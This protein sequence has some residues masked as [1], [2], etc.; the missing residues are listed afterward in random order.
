M[1]TN[2][3]GTATA[4]IAV[5]LSTALS[6]ANDNVPSGTIVGTVTSDASGQAV[7]NSSIPATGPLCISATY[8]VGTAAQTLAGCHGQ[9]Y[10]STA[11]LSFTI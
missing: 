7:F 6:G 5:T 4:G 11:T 9:P 1:T 10:P 8:T 2:V 3:S